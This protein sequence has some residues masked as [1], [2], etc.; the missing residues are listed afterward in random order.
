MRVCFV[1]A[2][3]LQRVDRGE[4]GGWFR[5]VARV[6]L[7][8]GPAR[9][10]LLVEQHHAPHLPRMPLGARL[11]ISALQGARE[12]ERR[13]ETDR[14]KDPLL[15]SC[16]LVARAARVGVDGER[17]ERERVEK[18]LR[19]LRR[20]VADE[21]ELGAV[22]PEFLD[23]RREPRRRLTAIESTE[24]T[25]EDQ[26]R[27]PALR[28]FGE[29]MRCTRGVQNGEVVEVGHRAKD[30]PIAPARTA[31]MRGMR[32]LLLLLLFSPALV[33]ARDLAVRPGSRATYVVDED[34]ITGKRT[35]R[36]NNDAVTGAIAWSDS[37]GRA[38][39]PATIFIDAAGFVT[40]TKG[41]DKKVPSILDAGAHPKLVFTLESCDPPLAKPLPAKASA[42]GTLE[43]HGVKKAIE[44]PVTIAIDAAAKTAT[45]EGSVRVVFEDFGMKPPRVPLIATVHDDLKLEIHLVV[46][47][48]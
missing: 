27:R 43:V 39:L 11:A 12:I 6:F 14:A 25:Q 29:R 47:A 46:D 22:L 16:E 33:S 34:F 1:D 7:D 15:E 38:V 21:E 31:R 36:G 9:L 24:V 4:H 42:R 2:A 8:V 28:E 13:L 18:P 23:L 44:V 19:V 3:D 48:P 40:G 41:R 5:D 45:V 10:S 26:D 32:A 17:P 20:P 30:T 35:A 37:A